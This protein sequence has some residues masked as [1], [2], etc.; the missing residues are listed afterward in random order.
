MAV[1]GKY[2]H[3]RIDYDSEKGVHGFRVTTLTA[4]NFDAQA[5]LRAAYGVA[6]A[7]ICGGNLNQHIH[8]NVD[9]QTEDASDTPGDQRELKW[10]V[11]YRDTTS[12]V[13][14]RVELP[15][16]K[17]AVLDPNKRGY[18][19]IGD[20][21]VVDAFVTAFEGFALSPTGGAV[22]VIDIQLVGRNV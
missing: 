4:L 6:V 18:A 5:T 13:K 12:N 19:E 10:L 16:A 8:G 15:C 3:T 9:F 14:Y 11:R 1:T 21:D 7:G 20:A 22:E 17:T 2:S